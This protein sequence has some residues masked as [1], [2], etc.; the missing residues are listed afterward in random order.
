MACSAVTTSHHVLIMFAA[1]LRWYEVAKLMAVKHHAIDEQA[2]RALIAARL[3]AWQRGRRYICRMLF[4]EREYRAG[5]V[6]DWPCG[7]SSSPRR[8]A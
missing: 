7:D 3:D 8:V 6:T 2:E 4:L 1:G 5:R